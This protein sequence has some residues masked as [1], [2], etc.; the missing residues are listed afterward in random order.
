MKLECY[1]LKILSQ[2]KFT[3]IFLKEKIWF[4]CR[5]HY[6][7]KYIYYLAYLK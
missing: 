7:L 5:H 2:N 6:H 1:T 3:K 4:Q